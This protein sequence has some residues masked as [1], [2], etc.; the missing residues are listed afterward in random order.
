FGFALQIEVAQVSGILV[1]ITSIT[2]E[3]AAEIQFDLSLSGWSEERKSGRREQQFFHVCFSKKMDHR[4]MAW[5]YRTGRLGPLLFGRN[6]SRPDRWGHLSR[7]VK[8]VNA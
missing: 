4:M 1:G 7:A 8:R 5:L 6:L 3:V 2:F